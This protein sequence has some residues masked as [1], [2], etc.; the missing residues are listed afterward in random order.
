M[1]STGDNGERVVFALDW[2][3]FA[4][5]FGAS[6]VTAVAF[7]LAPVLF[8][9]RLNVNDTLKCGARGTTGDRGHRRFRQVLIV[10]QFALAM[11][12]LSGAALFIRGLMN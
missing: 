9:L 3:V 5:A 1:R 12:L 2:R 11:I 8:A 7:G 6:L 10:G 4:W